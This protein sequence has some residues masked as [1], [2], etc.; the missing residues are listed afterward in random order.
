MRALAA[1]QQLP[2]INAL[3]A[4]SSDTVGFLIV[5]QRL[6]QKGFPLLSLY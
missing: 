4:M 3:V 6:N 2:S 1:Y 5:C